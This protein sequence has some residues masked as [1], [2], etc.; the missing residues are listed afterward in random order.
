MTKCA[1][2]KQPLVPPPPVW[3]LY[4]FEETQVCR[5]CWDATTKQ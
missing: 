3:I 4:L 5:E 1:R 2:C